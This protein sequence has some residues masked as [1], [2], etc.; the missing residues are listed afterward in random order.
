MIE[1]SAAGS[2]DA[3]SKRP[4]EKPG[5]RGPWIRLGVDYAGPAA[6]LAGYLIRHDIL[7]ATWALVGASAVALGVGFAV[8]RR[9]APLPLIW[10]LAALVFGVLTLI[11]HDPRIIKMKTT[12][13][14][15]ALGFGLLGGLAMGHSPIRIL[16][17]ESIALPEAA[18]RKLTL[19][20]GLF[21]LVLAVVN[22]VVWRTQPEAV[23]VAFRFPGLL[24]VSLLF[25]GTQIPLM[26]KQ[27]EAAETA[28]NLAESQE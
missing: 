5:E 1:P 22:E 24:I 23:W 26:M 3:S 16:M 8:E 13:I 11:F 25:A 27:A 28:V 7:T 9:V 21:F 12:I 10:G 4:P 20:F 17:G 15:A 2:P 18:W 14:D 6:F 19:R